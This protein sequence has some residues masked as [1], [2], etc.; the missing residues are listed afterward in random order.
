M[1]FGNHDH[2]T[3]RRHVTVRYRTAR[4]DGPSRRC[5]NARPG[6]SAVASQ[7]LKLFRSAAASSETVRE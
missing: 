5:S 7:N 1:N 6:R 4:R 2:P 3:V